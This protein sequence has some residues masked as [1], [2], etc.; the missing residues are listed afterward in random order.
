MYIFDAQSAINLKAYPQI[1]SLPFKMWYMV[2]ILPDVTKCD[3]NSRFIYLHQGVT[4]ASSDFAA[5]F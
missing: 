3:S 4:Y 2:S 1:L 5:E